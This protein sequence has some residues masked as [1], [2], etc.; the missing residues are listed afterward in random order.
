MIYFTINLVFQSLV[1]LIPSDEEK[2]QITEAKLANPDIPLGKEE[3]FVYTLSVIP[4]IRCRLNIWAFM[5]DFDAMEDEVGTNTN[6]FEFKN[7]Y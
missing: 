7:D 1:K 5:I 2:N 6:V 3:D 4:N